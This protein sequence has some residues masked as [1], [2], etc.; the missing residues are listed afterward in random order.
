MNLQA[1]AGARFATWWVESV[2]RTAEKD[3]ALDRRAEI[4]SDVHEQL[5]DA[6]HRDSLSMGSR[7]VVSRVVRGMPS[8]IVWR[9]GLELRPSRFAWHLRNPSTVI[10]ALFLV[11]VPVNM[12]ANSAFP[13]E[14]RLI[15][16]RIPLWVATDLIGS[17]IL[18]FAL[19]ALAARARGQWTAGTESYEPESRLE[20]ARRA[21]TAAMGITWAGAAVFRFGAVWP[22]GGFFWFAFAGCVVLYAVV[23]AMTVFVQLLILGRYLPKIGA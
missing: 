23:L 2:T 5:T 11:M 6:W 20:S 12:A 17:C 15:E 7:S 9:T 13:A 4:A 19:V 3:I 1:T 10:T 16:Y 22:V 18:L 21:I 8:D 14:R